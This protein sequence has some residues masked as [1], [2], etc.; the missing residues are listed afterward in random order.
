M[1]TLVFPEKTLQ[2]NPGL[3]NSP[4]Y[5]TAPEHSGSGPCLVAEPALQRHPVPPS[6]GDAHAPFSPTH[7]LRLA[8]PPWVIYYP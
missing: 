3:P 5:L 7:P 6:P 2:P 8:S 1:T 4:S